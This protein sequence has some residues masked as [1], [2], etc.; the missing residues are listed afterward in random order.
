MLPA[1]PQLRD[2]LLELYKM[3]DGDTGA[4]VSMF[5]V[6]TAIGLEKQE[7]GKTAEDLI[8]D[9]LAEVKTLSGGIGITPRGVEA[10]QASGMGPDADA[11]HLDLGKGPVLEAE[12]QKA[13]TSVLTDVKNTI[14]NNHTHYD[15]IEEA[16]IDI[17]T[18]EVQ[19][20]S[21]SPK[22]AIL[23]EVLKSIQ[24]A[25]KSMGSSDLSNKIGKM[26]N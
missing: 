2:Y 16:V 8:G 24:A 9:G 7:A 22:T 14:S 6:G 13:I 19:M 17:K 23:K 10:V 21:P 4:Q 18:I 26:V 12:G 15:R 11:P 5:D 20:L 3:T 25:L 1:T